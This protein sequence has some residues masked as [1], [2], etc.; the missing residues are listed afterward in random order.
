M[1]S[2]SSLGIVGHELSRDA[3]GTKHVR[4]RVRVCVTCSCAAG[5][6][7]TEKSV[8]AA[9]EECADEDDVCTVGSMLC[10]VAGGGSRDEAC[11]D[12]D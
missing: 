10:C 12:A 3:G 9:C 1:E 11:I 6:G 4:Y 7:E 8:C 5:G 2:V